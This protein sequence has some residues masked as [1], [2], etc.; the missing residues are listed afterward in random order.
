MFT[1]PQSGIQ[2][3]RIPYTENMPI[4]SNWGTSRGSNEVISGLLPSETCMVTSLRFAS[5]V[6][7]RH[8]EEVTISE[9][10]HRWSP[11]FSQQSHKKSS[12]DLLFLFISVYTDAYG[13]KE[14]P[15]FVMNKQTP[16]HR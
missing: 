5:S 3:T 7:L 9:S 2:T 16:V 6:C 10:L 14:V 8:G 12:K 13:D 11:L 4:T 15:W 1:R